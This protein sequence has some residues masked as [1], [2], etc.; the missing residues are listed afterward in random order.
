MTLPSETITNTADGKISIS[1]IGFEKA[2]TYVLTV[3]EKAGSDAGMEYSNASYD[4]T[5]VVKNGEKSLEIENV[6][7][8]ETV[9]QK[10]AEEAYDLPNESGKDASFVNRVKKGSLAITKTVAAP[11]GTEMKTGKY[12]F[13]VT[14]DGKEYAQDGSQ[15]D[16]AVIEVKAG[17]TVTVS[18]LPIG[19]YKVTEV[20]A[21]K[22]GYTWTVEVNGETGSETTVAV[23]D[24]GT[25]EAKYTNTYKEFEGIFMKLEGTKKL[26]GRALTAGEF[27]FEVS[28][29]SGEAANVTLPSETIT[30]TAD[31]KISISGIGFEKAGTYVLTVKE[32][33][34]S[35]AGMEY[36]NASY[37]VTVVVKNGEKS[38]EIES[39]KAGETVL[40]KNAEEAY[41][42]PN[43]S[44]KDASFVNRVKKGSLAITK[45]VDAPEGT[46]MKTGKYTFKV[47]R[48]GK[49]YAQ[50]RKPGRRSGHRGE[51]RRNCDSKQPPDWKLQGNRSGC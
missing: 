17:E 1:G 37:D 2:G 36:S 23:P 26:E 33:A 50:G 11:D 19:S 38:L 44:G 16:G 15:A 47:T 27:Q 3:K 10:N 35:D 8:G 7:T 45:T 9:L 14:R 46:E 25:A 32:K 12:T 24:K 6:K 39:V 29:K 28:L 49:E 41:D 21:E 22:A 34:G 48:D 30:N 43:E 40:Q 4:V 13:K 20:D 31:G 5:V 18:S 42:L 51:S